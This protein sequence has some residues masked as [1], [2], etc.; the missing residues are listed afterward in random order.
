MK[1]SGAHNWARFFSLD[2]DQIISV[3]TKATKKTARTA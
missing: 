3:T 1:M 2:G